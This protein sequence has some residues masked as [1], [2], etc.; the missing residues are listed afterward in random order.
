VATLR[1]FPLSFYSYRM[2]KQWKVGTIG[3]ILIKLT[4][5]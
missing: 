2:E 1:D 3:S 5:N 4:Y